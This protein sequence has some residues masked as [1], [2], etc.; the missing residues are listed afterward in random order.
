MN[1]DITVN[2]GKGLLDS[3]GL[4]DS[5]IEDCNN[6]V[7]PL[8]SGRYVLF[9]NML[10]QMVQKLSQLKTGVRSDISSRDKTIQELHEA[11]DAKGAQE[12]STLTD[13]L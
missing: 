1:E 11:I 10:V 9:C 3:I 6:I 2:D 12:C 4:I 8:I 13:T 7:Q 5:L